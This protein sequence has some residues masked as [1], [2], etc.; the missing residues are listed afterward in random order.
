MVD[1]IKFIL[2]VIV[3][4]SLPILLLGIITR[5]SVKYNLLDDGIEIRLYGNRYKKYLYNDIEQISYWDRE[6]SFKNFWYTFVFRDR[7][8]DL[9]RFFHPV[10]LKMV[11]SNY[12]I[13]LTPPSPVQFV[14]SVL[15][16]KQKIERLP[17]KLR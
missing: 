9:F 7:T 16:I 13:L 14:E 2:V 10:I 6:E 1:L 4:I 11:G 15:S 3:F 5:I 12:K 8:N 17:K